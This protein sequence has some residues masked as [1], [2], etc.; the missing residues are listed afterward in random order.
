[1]QC[2]QCQHENPSQAKF[3]QECGTRFGVAC[4]KCGSEIPGD[5]KF[6]RECGQAVGPVAT[7]AAHPAADAE[8]RQ[9][10]V[11][12]CDLVGSTALSQRLDAEELREVVRAHRETCAGVIQRF[13]GHLAKYLGD[14]VLVD[15]GYPKAHDSVSPKQP[16]HSPAA[17]LGR[18]F[19]R[20]SSLP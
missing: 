6:C 19:R 17:S 15:F 11:M 2:P 10:T 8:R 20:C 1:M 3:C 7:T 5:A 9:L 14:G 18:Y 12:F 13:E 4:V 16:I